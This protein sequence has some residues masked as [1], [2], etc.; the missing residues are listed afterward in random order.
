MVLSIWRRS[1]AAVNLIK[2]RINLLCQQMSHLFISEFHL[3]SIWIEVVCIW[4]CDG[5]NNCWMG[6]RDNETQSKAK[7]LMSLTWKNER[8]NQL[9]LS[10]LS[11]SLSPPTVSR[12]NWLNSKNN[13]FIVLDT[14]SAFS[15]VFDS[16]AVYLDYR[17]A[18]S[19][20]CVY[21]MVKLGIQIV[22]F[23]W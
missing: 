15:H 17:P 4:W 7:Q 5:C 19:R 21:I 6:R 12:T 8:K 16:F 11:L 18:L 13:R 9:C 2:F 20:E 1:N 3:L 23:Y 10:S 14:I 22:K